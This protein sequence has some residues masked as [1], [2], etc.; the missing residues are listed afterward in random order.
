EAVAELVSC[1]AKAAS[2]KEI[3]EKCGVIFLCLPS[4]A[5]SKQVLFGENGVASGLAPGKLVCDPSSV[6]PDESVYCHDELAKIGA[7][8]MDAPIS[9]GEPGAVAATLAIMCGGSEE[10]FKRLLPFFEI[11]GSS[12]VLIGGP[13]SGSVTKL[14]NQIIVNMNIAAVS[15]ALVLAEKCGADP[16]KVY[17]AIRGGLAGSAVLDAKAPMMYER[18]FKAGGKISINHKDLKNVM[19]TAIANSVPL[20]MTAE[21]YQVYQTMMVNGHQD[22]DHS[23]IVQYFEKL[24]GVE[25]KKL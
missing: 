11:I 25:V 5:I 10:D 21:L 23:A 3:G 16:E 20:P 17:R 19:N 6:T 14:A 8:F 2:L 24:A 4:G 9:G 22:E 13:G 12:A 7:G 15:E 18:N 1:G